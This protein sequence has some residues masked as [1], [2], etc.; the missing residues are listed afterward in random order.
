MFL[1]KSQIFD[2]TKFCSGIS[3]LYKKLPQKGDT[4]ILI[5]NNGVLGC[6]YKKKSLDLY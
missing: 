3:P 4:C 2:Q 5:Q 6:S 1:Q